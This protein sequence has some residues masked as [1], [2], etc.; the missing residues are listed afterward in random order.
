MSGYVTLR[1][2]F[3]H[4]KLFAELWVLLCFHSVRWKSCGIACK[5]FPFCPVYFK[6]TV[7]TGYLLLSVF[8]TGWVLWVHLV[9]GLVTSWENVLR[10]QGPLYVV[11]WAVSYPSFRT[12]LTV[13][14]NTVAVLCIASGWISPVNWKKFPAFYVI[15]RFITALTRARHLSLSLTGSVQFMASFHLTFWRSFRHHLRLGPPSCPFTSVFP[16]KTL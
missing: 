7:R 5:S 4:I 10:V 9:L 6:L 1:T 15:R 14:K 2:V 3:I 8:P 13:C 11:T 12:V 16:I